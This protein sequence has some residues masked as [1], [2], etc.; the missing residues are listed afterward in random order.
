MALFVTHPH[1]E[2]Y[3]TANGNH[4]HLAFGI[5]G[6]IVIRQEDWQ[7]IT[8]QLFPETGTTNLSRWDVGGYEDLS[9]KKEGE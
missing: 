4:I 7:R 8:N 3:R 6:R 2:L 9:K 1:A 5:G